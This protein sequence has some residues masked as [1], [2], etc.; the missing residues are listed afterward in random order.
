MGP[1]DLERVV[2]LRRVAE[3]VDDPVARKRLAQVI[4]ALRRDIGVGV[5]KRR[6]ARLLGVSVQALERW[7]G[8][9]LLPTVRKPG[10]T[11]TLLDAEAVIVLAEEVA[12]R[13]ERGE[14]RAVVAASLRDLERVGRLPRKLRPNE[15]A[16]EL[17]TAFRETTPEERLRDVAELSRT[18]VTL[19]ARGRTS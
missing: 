1:T 10:S 15:T 6:A 17:R 8:R 4:R 18:A 19:A 12:Q 16:H 3:S 7:V 14:D 9:G 5:P 13:R 11:R 2:V